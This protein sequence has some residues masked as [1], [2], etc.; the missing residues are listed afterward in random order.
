MTV[1]TAIEIGAGGTTAPGL[2]KAQGT[3]HG[4]G[5]SGSTAQGFISSNDSGEE[6]FR[7]GWQS[8]LASLGSRVE[9][10]SEDEADLGTTFD[11]P[12]S[13]QSSVKPSV[14]TLATSIRLRQ[15]MGSEKGSVETGSGAELS[16]GG[17]QTVYLVA[18]PAAGATKQTTTKTEE[19]NQ[20]AEPATESAHSLRPAR[21]INATKADAVLADPL[22]GLIPAT[23]ASLSQAAPVAVLVTPAVQSM[24]EKAQSAQTENSA[25]LSTHQP[26]AFAS[27]SLSPQPQER[28]VFGNHAAAVNSV[29][30]KTAEE[31]ETSAQPGQTLPGPSLSGSSAP[32]LS[33]TNT[34]NADKDAPP[35]ISV[36]AEDANLPEKPSQPSSLI[37]ISPTDARNANPVGP[38]APSQVSSPALAPAQSRTI[39]L[40]QDHHSI[41]FAAPNE[42]PTEAIAPIQASSQTL[43]TNQYLSPTFVQSQ[44]QAPAQQQNQI[45]VGTTMPGDGLNSL[46]VSTA[47]AASQ[48]S[49][50]AALPSVL[51]KPG[52]AG[53][54]KVSTPEALRPARGVSNVDSVQHASQQLT[55]HSSVTAVDASAMVHALAGAGGTVSIAGEPAGAVN[56]AAT[57]P[58]TREAFATLDTAAT[59]EKPTWIRAGAQRA[60]AGYQD[61]A[62]GWVSVR[63][64]LSGGGVH[65]QL[66]PGSADAAQAL[67]SHLAGLN[68]YLD[69]HHTPV[70]TLTLTSPEGGW[71]QMGSGRGTGEGM[72]QGAGQQTGQG[73]SQN[74]DAGYQSGPY[75]ESL[76]QTPAA[77]QELPAF[78]GDIDG[79]AQ[80]AS[81]GRSHISVMA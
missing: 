18:Q 40:A 66:V 80:A 22:T 68:A 79:S 60:E 67:G 72:Q 17:A 43:V 39:S 30:Q 7:A 13:E 37:Q 47:V 33:E 50:I 59:P 42:T 25:G 49:Q 8:L 73:M 4:A 32:T 26:A 69:E 57:R 38:P 46:P 45:M 23:S 71:S 12:A 19:T 28:N 24:A 15:A 52:A 31:V 36:L 56:V 62:L 3:A 34:S 61:P 65:A 11:G 74:A 1:V 64:D 27:A 29:A 75:S 41:Q 5:R 55:G 53:G 10:F 70:E 78:F 77:S 48:S 51:G 58:D 76:I 21:S 35:A 9:G 16:S 20:A 54:G 63:A 44:G 2:G 81:L 14:S 6:G